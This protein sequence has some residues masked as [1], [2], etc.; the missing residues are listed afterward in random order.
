MGENKHLT[1]VWIVYVDG[2]RLDTD[3]EGALERIVI[4]DK[5]NGVG[6]GVL[7]FDSSMIK[8]RDSGTFS[9]ESYVSVH[10]GYKDDCEQVFAGEVTEFKGDFS[11][12]GHERVKV[13]CKNCLH[14]LQNAL[15]S[16]S[17]EAK[18]P[19]AV[20]KE[21]LGVYGLKGEIEDF[22][23]VRN[24][25]VE[26]GL[27]D[28][29]YLLQTARKYGKTVY[30][31]DDTVYIKDEVTVSDEEVI[32]EWGKSLI[33]FR[34][35]ENLKGQL[36]GCTFVGWD[37]NNCEGITGSAGLSD[38]PVKVGGDSSWED[39]SKGASGTWKTVFM[40][41][42]LYDNEDAKKRAIGY[43]QN[44]SMEYQTGVGKCEGNRHIFP[45]MRVTMKY[46]GEHFSGEYI[47]E[48]VVHEV[49]VNGPFTTEVY[50]KRN[51]SEG[52]SQE[53]TVPS[54]VDAEMS[55]RTVAGDTMDTGE[56]AGSP[57]ETTE[58]NDATDSSQEAASAGAVSSPAEEEKTTE[59]EKPAEEEESPVKKIKQ[60]CQDLVGT[61][62]V[63]EGPNAYMCDDFVQEVLMTAGY[64]YS[65]YMAGL[66]SQHTV[67]DHIKH[68]TGFQ[69]INENEE[70][71]YVVYMDESSETNIAHA[72]ILIVEPDNETNKF[73]VFDNSSKNTSDENPDG[74][75]AEQNYDSVTKFEDA[76][77]YKKFYY[78]K[79]TD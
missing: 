24:Y 4:D 23:A 60:I 43:L 48:R 39:N 30:G 35:S 16:L 34:C 8:I 40:A 22:G 1:P 44:I 26:S 36:S 50:V 11:E 72:A 53:N 6:T 13:V 54:S 21:R 73:T 74:G 47:A 41:D 17:F 57:S 18:S 79:I 63:K 75:V 9:L 59:E 2:K 71:A 27:S 76:F 67:Q 64:Q 10:L 51:M 70:G 66:A 78:K 62:Y 56:E 42:D 61:A 49:S 20:L 58:I 19:A 14:K 3:H 37:E 77:I 33:S 65:D 29:E 46:V 45:G 68:V 32:L 7:E 28:Y 12:Y 5:L 55:Q 38:I 25:F 69:S 52:A 15:Q 31:Y